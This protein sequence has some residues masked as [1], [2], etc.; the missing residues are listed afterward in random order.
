M[1]ARVCGSVLQCVAVHSSRR[2]WVSVSHA[3][4]TVQVELSWFGFIVEVPPGQRLDP[5]AMFVRGGC[6]GF[7]MSGQVC[8]SKL[9]V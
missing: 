5:P 8:A 3:Y 1:R 6:L 9:T 7:V 2:Q 4:C